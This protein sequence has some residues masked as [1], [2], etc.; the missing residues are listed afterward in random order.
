MLE[1]AD[2]ALA[3]NHFPAVAA[4]QHVVI[5][6]ALGV[7]QRF[8]HRFA[9]WLADQGIAVT[10]FDYYGIGDSKNKP[11][12]AIDTDIIEWATLDLDHVLTWASQQR[13]SA[14][15]IWLGHSLGGQL[16]GLIPQPERI[17]RIVTV[18]SGTGY[19]LKAS[20]QVK[21]TSWLLWYLAIP[22]ATPIAG[23]FPG[24][25]LNMVGDM[26]ARAMRQWSRWCRSRNY[27][28]DHLSAEQLE[29]YQRL[30]QPYHAFSISDDE[31][32]VEDNVRALLQRY[33]NTEQKL[34]RLTPQQAGRR[35]GHFN[36]FKPTHQHTLWQQFLLPAIT[37]NR[38]T[39]PAIEES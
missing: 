3:I 31:L 26:P 9:Q 19:W 6:P 17:N 18:A 35:I 28:F 24:K 27:L 2:R 21:R 38:L 5:A 20:A 32:L 15:L 22:L 29:G 16:L 11:L 34:T 14:E 12:N 10:C 1:Y 23:Y 4:Q 39:H 33:P 37:A 13:P 8:Y 30:T 25:R 7:K 36:I